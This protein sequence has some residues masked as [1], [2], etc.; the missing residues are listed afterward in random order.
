MSPRSFKM[1][2]W[3]ARVTAGIIAA[4]F[5]VVPV[6]ALAAGG[7]GVVAAWVKT[8]D[9]P[10]GWGD[11]AIALLPAAAVGLMFCGPLWCALRR[12]RRLGPRRYNLDSRTVEDAWLDAVGKL[13]PVVAATPTFIVLAIVKSVLDR[14]GDLGSLVRP[15]GA[16]LLAAATVGAVY[17]LIGDGWAAYTKAIRYDLESGDQARRR[18]ALR[19]GAARDGR[20]YQGRWKPRALRRS[21]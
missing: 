17:S 4:L 1:W 12:M 2:Q 10:D 19:V 3:T 9:R 13:V 14:T 7:I 18:D 20:G 15:L 6:A 11:L 5:I 16:F 8:G 21:G